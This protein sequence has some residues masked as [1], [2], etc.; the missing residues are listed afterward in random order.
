MGLF[1]FLKKAI[2]GLAKV[3]LSRLTGGVSDK[4]LS[5]LKGRGLQKAPALSL[6]QQALLNKVGPPA[7]RVKRTE[8]DETEGWGF[9]RAKRERAMG[10]A[11]VARALATGRLSARG[12]YELEP[13]VAPTR[14]RKGKKGRKGHAPTGGLDLKALSASWKAAGKPG[15]WPQWIQANK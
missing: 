4:V 2:G 7:M 15:S 6:A 10:K 11:A 14:S 3:G 12:G 13:E 9:S 5:V 1:G 8:T